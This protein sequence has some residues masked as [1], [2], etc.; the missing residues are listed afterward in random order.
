MARQPRCYQLSAAV[1]C[2]KTLDTG[3]SRRTIVPQN[4]TIGVASAWA[5]V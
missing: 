1:P 5:M 4:V 3:V 2:E